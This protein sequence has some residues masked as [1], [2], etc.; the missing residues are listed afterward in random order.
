MRLTER[1]QVKKT[2][3]ISH[4]GHRAKNLYNQANYIIRQR[5]FKDRYWVRYNELYHFL[6]DEV[7]FRNL[8]IQTSQQILRLLDKNWKSFFKAIKDWKKHPETQKREDERY[9]HLQKQYFI[10]IINGLVKIKNINIASV[11]PK[12]PPLSFEKKD[13]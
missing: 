4:L 10:D 3:I 7:V 8:N 6:K 1:I 13:W 9:A 5:F 12:I 2:R 11:I